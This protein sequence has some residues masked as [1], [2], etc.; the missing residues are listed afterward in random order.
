MFNHIRSSPTISTSEDRK[1]I[2]IY[3]KCIVTVNKKIY[4]FKQNYCLFVYPSIIQLMEAWLFVVDL[5]FTQEL[6]VRGSFQKYL[7]VGTRKF[8]L[9]A[10]NVLYC[11]HLHI[12]IHET[13][14]L[15]SLKTKKSPV[16]KQSVRGKG[17]GEGS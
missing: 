14:H 4:I 10:I 17:P 15:L 2:N 12:S 7:L 1:K 8:S 5:I 11:Q 13:N 9:G 16:S 6:T 3:L